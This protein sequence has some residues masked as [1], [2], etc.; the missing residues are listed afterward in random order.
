MHRLGPFERL[1]AALHWVSASSARRNQE[2]EAKFRENLLAANY[3]YL[4][5]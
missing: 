5:V 4:P 3:Y 1:G 2:E